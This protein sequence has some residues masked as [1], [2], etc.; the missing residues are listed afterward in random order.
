MRH[1]THFVEEVT[2]GRTES[3]GRMVEVSRIEP[4]PNQPRKE[5]GDLTDLVASIKEKGILEPILVRGHGAKY[6]II[7]GERRFQAAKIAGLR[8]VPCVELDVDL[9]GMLEISLIENLQ[10]KDLHAFEEA[11]AIQSLTDQ[12]RYT[13]EE[14]ARKLGK[15]RPVITETLSLCRIPEGVRERCRQADITSKSMLL[16]IARQA[17]GDAMDKLI[18]QISGGGM[19]REEA[20]RFNKGES[21]PGRRPRRYTF[22]Y[23]PEGDASFQFSMTFDRPKVERTEVIE[24]LKAILQSLIEDE[25]SSGGEL[26]SADTRQGDEAGIRPGAELSGSEAVGGQA[27]D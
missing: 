25:L 22:R 11:E 9:R 19:T 18:D 15:S 6:Q 20:R 8:S 7:A 13:H 27:D 16:Q 12:F 1:D 14:I 3:I 26:L 23:K 17:D 10:R 5:F 21:A 24:R 4:N 2:S